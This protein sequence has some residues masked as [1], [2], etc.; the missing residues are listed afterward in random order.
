MPITVKINVKKMSR[1]IHSAVKK[2]GPRAVSEQI[3]KSA[4]TL[5]TYLISFIK[6]AVSKGL[7]P[8][9]G[10]GRFP[11]Y[12]H[13][14]KISAAIKAG[15]SEISGSKSIKKLRGKKNAAAKEQFKKEIM[16]THRELVKKFYPESVA[17]EFPSKK[18]RP[19]NLFL[20]GKFLESLT[21]KKIK[22]GIEL[23]FF[24]HFE[25]YE[26]GHREGANGQPQRP[27]V[28]QDREEFSRSI[29]TRLEAI[30]ERLFY[31]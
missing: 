15:K 7:S 1:D 22:D 14:R 21:F 8:I 13:G 25:E 29:M 17:K 27:I 12:L 2:D 23:G 3:N 9:K 18:L 11:E 19:V 16:S 31:K 20:S 26:R 4:E 30:L 28:P 24:N 10:R 6:D 5:G